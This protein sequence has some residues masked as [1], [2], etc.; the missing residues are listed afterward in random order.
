MTTKPPIQTPDLLPPHDV[1]TERGVLS[2][3]LQ[4]AAEAMPECGKVSDACFYD[5]RNQAVWKAI[6]AL[7]GSQVA[8]DQITVSRK[9]RE[10]GD[11]AVAT[12][13]LAGL[14]DES[15]SPLNLPYY[16]PT[17]FDFAIKRWVI[18][19]CA[20]LTQ[21]ARNGISA[22]ELMANA[23]KFLSVDRPD[24]VPTL[25]G[26]AAGIVLIDDLQRRHDLAGAHS[27][28]A[29]GFFELDRLLDGL[30]Y[31]EQTLIG[32]RPSRGKTALG[33]CIYHKVVFQ[34]KVP[35]LFVSLEMSASS[36]MRRLLSAHCEISMG[37]IRRGS[38][39][40]GDFQKMA[41]FHGATRKLP[42]F[43]LDGITGISCN[44][45]CCQVRRLVRKH[46]IKLVIV[47]YLT[48]VRPD[49]R[50]EKRTYEVAEVS[51]K[52]KALANE[53]KAAF[54]TLVQLNRENEKDKGRPPRLSDLGDSGQIERDADTVILIDR[55]GSEPETRLIVAKQRDGETGIANVLFNG[56][57]CRFE[58]VPMHT[59]NLPH[60]D[61][62]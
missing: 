42:L 1:G 56:R 27:G 49:A 44:E 57:Y 51:G 23:E 16:L 39:S 30:Q 11:V 15:P 12:D 60:N 52:L 62:H 43:I 18:R 61:E 47:D 41:T 34:E 21:S 38:Y 19:G 9:L 8:I 20:R 31:G 25:N 3:I 7:H 53:T 17:L 58:N 40:E 4:N 5:I 46:G 32:A 26:E 28:I 2:C 50:H 35:S 55:K 45:L 48:K 54:L 22:A 6:S 37:E 14:L 36:L 29:T 10:Q 59:P 13:Y 33:L 24:A